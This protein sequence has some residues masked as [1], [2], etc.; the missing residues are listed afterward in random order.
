M[1]ET[2]L[3]I[4]VMV[5]EVRTKTSLEI[6]EEKKC[7]WCRH[8][9]NELTLSRALDNMISLNLRYSSSWLFIKTGSKQMRV[10]K[11]SLSL[12]HLFRLSSPDRPLLEQCFSFFGAPRN[13]RHNVLVLR[14]AI[15]KWGEITECEEP[16]GSK[17]K[18]IEVKERNK[19]PNSKNRAEFEL[20][21]A[22]AW[23]RCRQIPSWWLH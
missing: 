17:V 22:V 5:G 7:Q 11:F 2:S 23:R 3:H 18:K 12:V 4:G 13:Y 21:A 9:P 20:R 19:K 16:K 8:V 14:D 1:R 15:W 6:G 10:A